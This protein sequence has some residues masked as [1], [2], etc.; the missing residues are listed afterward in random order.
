MPL[1]DLIVPPSRPEL[2]S[3]F[4]FANQ[5]AHRRIN[6]AIFAKKGNILPE[7][8]LDPLPARDFEE[9]LDLHAAMH[10]NQ[11]AVLGI[12]GYALSEVDWRDPSQLEAWTAMHYQEHAQA[13]LILGIPS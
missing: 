11:N 4:A 9:W 6:A 13:V 8:V 2:V 10:I 1:A 7:Y 12:N 3:A 5:D